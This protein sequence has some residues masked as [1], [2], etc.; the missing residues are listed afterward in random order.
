[1]TIY[2]RQLC[3]RMHE[4]PY[5]LPYPYQNLSLYAD[6]IAGPSY[7]FVCFADVSR[8]KAEVTLKLER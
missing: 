8:K 5:C 6:E 4:N 1:M 2:F 7:N 3:T